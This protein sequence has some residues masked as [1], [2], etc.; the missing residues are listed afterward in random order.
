MN[1][2]PLTSKFQQIL[3]TVE[4]LNLEDQEI[5]IDILQKRFYQHKRQQLAQEIKEIRQEYQQGKVK[6]GTVADLM[7]EL[8]SYCKRSLITI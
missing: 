2:T 8:D 4:A 3:E 6:F 5:L 7:A 1:E